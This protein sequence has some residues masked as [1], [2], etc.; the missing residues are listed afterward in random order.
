MVYTITYGNAGQHMHAEDVT[1]MTIRP[2]GTTP[3][4][5]DWHSSDGETYIYDVGDLPAGDT[6]HTVTF[7]VVHADQPEIEGSMYNTPFTVAEDRGVSWDVS[8]GNNATVDYIGVPDLVVTHFS[9]EP[10]P[11]EAEVPVT[12]TIVVENQGTGIAWNPDIGAGCWSDVFIAS[13]ASY[14]WERFSEKNIYAG[15]D[16]LAPGAQQ[17]LTVTHYNGT[18]QRIQFSEQEIRH[19]I[20]A[21]YVKVDN[22]A[23]AVY[24][25]QERIIGWTRLYGLV[26]EYNEMNNVAGPVDLGFHYVYL[27]MVT[28]MQ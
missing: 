28:R 26:P 15:I 23:E 3:I 10:Y 17:I 27:P 1:I 24:D 6:G 21:F 7:E 11:L 18:A 13:V 14:P 12:F 16:P 4:S 22:Y 5:P 9:F 25:G 2:P 8:P 19:E 20:G